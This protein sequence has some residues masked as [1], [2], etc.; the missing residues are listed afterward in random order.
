MNVLKM[1]IYLLNNSYFCYAFQ[2]F[3]ASFPLAPLLALLTNLFDIR[4]DAWRMLWWY[5]RPIAVIAEDIGTVNRDYHTA[6]LLS[7]EV[8][9]RDPI[10]SPRALTCGLIMVEG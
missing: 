2:L 4:V 9:T 8:S 10:I 1:E 3:A 6:F 5:Q 7:R